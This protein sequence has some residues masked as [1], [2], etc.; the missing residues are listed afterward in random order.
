MAYGR[1][2]FGWLL[3]LAL[4]LDLVSAGK[5]IDFMM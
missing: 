5:S 1:P 3:E 4:R 2:A